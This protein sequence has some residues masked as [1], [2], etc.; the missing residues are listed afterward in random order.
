MKWIL[1]LGLALGFVLAA[2]SLARAD[3]DDQRY[4]DVH[5]TNPPYENTKWP[6]KTQARAK[7]ALNWPDKTGEQVGETGESTAGQTRDERRAKTS[8]RELPKQPY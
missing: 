4:N 3:D 8:P 6:K 7:K 1:R 5:K 2:P